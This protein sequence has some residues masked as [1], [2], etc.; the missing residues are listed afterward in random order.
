MNISNDWY[1][2]VF[3]KNSITTVMY[4]NNSIV[5]KSACTIVTGVGDWKTMCILDIICFHN[6]IVPIDTILS[7][8]DSRTTT[9]DLKNNVVPKYAGTIVTVVGDWKTM[10][11]S[12]VIHLYNTIVPIG[13]IVSVVGNG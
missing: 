5:L 4:L 10:C 8:V 11:L 13:T 6:M 7:V 9:I 3:F 2:E 1:S 12:D